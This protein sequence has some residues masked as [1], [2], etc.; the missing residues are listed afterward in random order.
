MLKQIL[1][2]TRMRIH[3]KSDGGQPFQ[4]F[5]YN[6]V[7]RAPSNPHYSEYIFLIF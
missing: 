5:N 6:K 2:N 1:N 4:A 7:V 3:L